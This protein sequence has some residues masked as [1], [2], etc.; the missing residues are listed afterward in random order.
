MVTTPA[1]FGN[2]KFVSR[3]PDKLGEGEAGTPVGRKRPTEL[4]PIVQRS[5]VCSIPGRGTV[6]SYL[7]PAEVTRYARQITLD[8]WGRDAQERLKSSQ[9]FIAG[10]GGLASATALY[11]MAGG[12]GAMRLVDDSRVSLADLNHQV[13][14]R[15]RDLGKAKAT[16]AERRLK[17]INPF[18]T[19]ESHVKILS[20]NNVF[21]LAASCDVL[22]DASNNAG[23][24]SL[25]NL[26]AARQ[27]I[28]LVHAWVWEMTGLLTTFWP[29]R[30]PCQACADLET[31]SNHRP[32]LLGPLP[33]IM[34]A[35]QALEVLRILGGLGPALLGRV[36]T[37]KGTQFTFT[38][39]II[40][41]NP[42][43]PVCAV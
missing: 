32:A 27:Q 17:E 22:I 23:V 25:L 30:G 18:V 26:V 42:L 15:E 10:A 31:P 7:S 3:F 4:I 43:C 5:A 11:L 16:M 13:L 12:L 2:L 38:E 36:L 37:F 28:P 20:E 6:I 24:G 39:K 29:S 34:G 1:A 21:R 19:V 33:G 41:V 35:L 14:F 40:R 8:G 9:V